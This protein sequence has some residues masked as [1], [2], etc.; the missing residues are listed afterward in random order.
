MDFGPSFLD[1]IRCILWK[2]RSCLMLIIY[3]FILIN[4][5]IIHIHTYQYICYHG[6]T[7]LVLSGDEVQTVSFYA[8]S[9]SYLLLCRLGAFNPAL[10]SFKGILVTL[11]LIDSAILVP[12]ANARYKFFV[13]LIIYIQWLGSIWWYCV[14]VSVLEWEKWTS[15][16]LWSNIHTVAILCQRLVK[17]NTNSI[18]QLS[19][20]LTIYLRKSTYK[21]KGLFWPTVLGVPVYDQSTLLLWACS[22]A[23]HHGRCRWQSKTASLMAGKQKTARRGLEYHSSLWE[24]T[25]KD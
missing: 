20:T 12:K 3:T 18:S 13:G 10:N 4:M 19:I 11:D 8:L 2:I 23:A 22:E 14:P 9:F 5:H 7:G 21:E 17:S 6:Y 1:D 16:S 15:V 24:L 25:N